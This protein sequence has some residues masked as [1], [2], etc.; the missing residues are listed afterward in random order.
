MGRGHGVCI[1]KRARDMRGLPTVIE[2]AGWRTIAV[3]IGFVLFTTSCG[4][5]GNPTAASPNEASRVTNTGTAGPL[6]VNTAAGGF[7]VAAPG[8]VKRWY[9]TFG[10][11]VLC[12]KGAVGDVTVDG[13]RLDMDPST[14]PLSVRPE[15]RNV[16]PT[17]VQ[18]DPVTVRDDYAPVLGALLGKPP[19]RQRYASGFGGLGR[20]TDSL[21]NT[22]IASSCDQTTAAVGAVSSGRVPTTKFSELNFVVRVDPAGGT[23]RRALVDYHE[24]VVARTLVINWRMTACGDAVRRFCRG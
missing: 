6:T 8:H 12:T 13:V 17:D 7:A 10:N 5:P 23:I 20:F 3:T 21:A 4:G 24:G 14:A 2:W 11:F 1:P 22:V 18:K 9:A 15:L 19:F 16:V